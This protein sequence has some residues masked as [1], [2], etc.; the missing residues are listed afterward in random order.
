M[1]PDEQEWTMARASL[2]LPERLRAAIEE[3]A[4]KNNRSWSGEVRQALQ[5][6]VERETAEATVR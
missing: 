1:K 5:E 6:Y 3:L 2:A 4:E